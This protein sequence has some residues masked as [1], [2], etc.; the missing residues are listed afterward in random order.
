MRRRAA[1]FATLAF[2]L[3]SVTGIA[4]EGAGATPI[5]VFDSDNF[6]DGFR[7]PSMAQS[8]ALSTAFYEESHR[9]LQRELRKKD[10]RYGK[11]AIAL[12]DV[13]TSG[14]LPLPLSDTWLHE[15]FHR[16]VM[17]N[18]GVSSF[19]DV[20][21]FKPVPFA[22]AVSHVRD[23]A[24]ARM[25]RDHPADFVRLSA[26]GIEGEYA[27]GYRLEQNEF[28]RQSKSYNAPL[29]L[30]VKLNSALYVMSGT[31]GETQ[32]F[33]ERSERDEGTN[34]RRRDFTG[35]DFTAWVYDLFRP[36][37]PYAARGVHPSGVGIRRYRRPSD[38]TAEEKRYLHTVGRRSL[39]NFLDPNLAGIDDFRTGSMRWNVAASSIL[40]SFGTATDLQ[41]FVQRGRRVSPRIAL[42]MQPR[43]QMF[44]THAAQTGALAAL[45]LRRGRLALELEA[46]SAGWVQANVH[47]ERAVIA[48][49]GFSM[50]PSTWAASP[51]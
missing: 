6:V 40:T 31:S 36:D 20:Y 9:L 25:K 15:E 12:F 42:W 47:L 29:Y 37:E 38:L 48:R 5:P 17:S 39:L 13:I 46:K 35:H 16:A 27:L 43:D 26:A 11:A 34:V 4:G 45:S 3:V 1:I 41:A 22:I 18:R 28:F 8:L 32:R 14:V 21:H 23:D 33:T 7:G 24:L 51:R 30:F 44:R 49:V 2:L 50:A 10:E 19:D